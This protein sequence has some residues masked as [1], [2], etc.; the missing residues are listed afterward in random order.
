[1]ASLDLS[2]PQ[3]LAKVLLPKVPLIFKTAALHSLSLSNTSSK[4]DLKTELFV[5]IIRSF[6]ENPKPEPLSKSQKVSIRDP[7]VKGNLWVSRYTIP[8][9]AEQDLRQA[10]F[11]AIDETKEGNEVY[12]QPDYAPIYVEW[13][14]YRKDAKPD[15]PELNISETEKYENLMKEVISEVVFLYFHGGAYYM[16]E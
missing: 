2:S 15:A 5:N 7:G 1:M 4:W 16:M 12:T 3:K 11:K 13:T 10:L 9:P 8:I 14:G 6:L